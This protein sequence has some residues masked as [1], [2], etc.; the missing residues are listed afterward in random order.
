MKK[1]VLIGIFTVL[2]FISLFEGT[3]QSEQE[4]YAVPTN[5]ICQEFTKYECGTETTKNLSFEGYSFSCTYLEELDSCV[6]DAYLFVRNNGSY[7]PDE[8]MSI[9]AMLIAIGVMFLIIAFI[10]YYIIP[11]IIFPKKNTK[12]PKRNGL[13]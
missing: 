6:S 5:E 9:V 10:F 4:A 8:T 12:M 7:R 13:R 1:I 2:F 3:T 11:R